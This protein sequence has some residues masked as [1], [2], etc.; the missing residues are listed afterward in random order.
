MKISTKGRYALRLMLDLALNNTG[1]YITIKS[2]AARQ[3]I[4]EKYLEQ[5]ISLLNRAN[6]VKSVRGAQGGYRLAK[7]PAEYTVGMIL[8]LTEG[9]LAPVDCLEDETNECNR[10][11]TCVTKDV[12]KELY[13]AISSVVDHITLQNLVDKQLNM[14]PYDFSI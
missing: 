12:Y 8:R 13:E 1:E 11:N 2:I 9:S 10:W 4:S 5:I 6:Y 3:E 14:V 7:E